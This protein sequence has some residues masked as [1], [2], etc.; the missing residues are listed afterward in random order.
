[1]HELATCQEIIDL[2]LSFEKQLMA[3]ALANDLF[4]FLKEILSNIANA[5]DVWN[6][7]TLASGL[8]INM[9]KSILVRCTQSDLVDL[10][11]RGQILHQKNVSRHLGYY[12][13][14]DFSLS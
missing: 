13:V 11:W 7:F 2:A 14:D 1:M 3:P 4:S 10:G 6:V 8:H 5:M 9:R 12:I